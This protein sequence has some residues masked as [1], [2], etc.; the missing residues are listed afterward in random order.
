M[1]SLSNAHDFG[2]EMLIDAVTLCGSAFLFGIYVVLISFSTVILI[3]KGLDF[4]A[5]KVLLGVTFV[6]FLTSTGY[7]V[8]LFVGY[9]Q[10]VL[11][12]SFVQQ[13]GAQGDEI[14]AAIGSS[15]SLDIALFYLSFFNYVSGDAII[16][17]R[18]WALWPDN[19][20]VVMLP[21]G[22]LIGS[23]ASSLVC[24]GLEI[25][26]F[27]T[28]SLRIEKI[29]GN[30]QLASWALSLAT[31]VV[32]T[33]LIAYKAWIHRK[34]IQSNMSSG[35]IRRSKAGKIMSLL[36][37][38]GVVYCLVWITLMF[39]SY[40]NLPNDDGLAGNLFLPLSVQI[41]G[42][43]PTI[44]IVLVS[45]EK[46]ILGAP[47]LTTAGFGSRT[48]RLQFATGPVSESLPRPQS[49]R[50]GDREDA[51]KSEGV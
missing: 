26:A 31:S 23:I 9:V 10:Q 6:M 42:I 48:T 44:I 33:L 7:G 4:R 51:P 47:S 20:K 45:L 25:R 18:A 50:G 21:I 12:L 35:G 43:Y 40:I 32:A 3:R 38:S 36:A 15:F 27:H 29:G 28:Q 46:T 22:L 13:G 14:Y 1:S 2:Y 17:W 19:R 24:G 11:G 8:A 34:F 16:V 5:N 37:E 41:T 30:A 39:T 49:P